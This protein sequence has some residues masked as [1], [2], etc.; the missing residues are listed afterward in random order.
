MYTVPNSYMP[1]MHITSPTIVRKFIHWLHHAFTVGLC[2]QLTLQFC[3][4]STSAVLPSRR[5]L[6]YTSWTK[7]VTWLALLL[8]PKWRNSYLGLQSRFFT[9]RPYMSKFGAGLGLIRKRKV[10]CRA[11]F[12]P[13]Q[14]QSSFSDLKILGFCGCIL[15]TFALLLD[16]H[17]IRYQHN[18][19]ESWGRALCIEP[20]SFEWVLTHPKICSYKDEWWKIPTPCF[21]PDCVGIQRA[22]LPVSTPLNLFFNFGSIWKSKKRYG[23]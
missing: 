11:L 4:D 9:I 22:A 6:V 5:H 18:L 20:S 15:L 19:V 23:W 10:Q 21:G 16:T 14:S 3:Y 1:K 17:I 7:F 2:I 13:F 8:S 12:S